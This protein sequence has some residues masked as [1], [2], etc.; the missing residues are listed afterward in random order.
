MNKEI[1]K[2]VKA[3][4]AAGFECD[5]TRKGRITVRTAR[6]DYVTTL[7]PTATERHGLRNAMAPLRRL[8][9]RWPP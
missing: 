2:I 7:S 8:G 6:G 3:L 5:T 1:R 4:E 9:F